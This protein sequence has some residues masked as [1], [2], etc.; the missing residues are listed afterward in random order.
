M[1]YGLR[2]L[3]GLWTTRDS[4]SQCASDNKPISGYEWIAVWA[5]LHRVKE[6]THENNTYT[7]TVNRWA[8]DSNSLFRRLNPKAVLRFVTDGQ[9]LQRWDES[10]RPD[11]VKN[12][13]PPETRII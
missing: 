11:R 4:L 12:E 9:E 1:A 13:V 5:L 2:N 6:I 7:I 8:R 3:S 10:D